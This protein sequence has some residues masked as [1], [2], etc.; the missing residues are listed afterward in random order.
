MKDDSWYADAVLWAV[1]NGITDGLTDTTFAPD[2]TCTRSQ[3]V[4]FLHRSHGSRT[5]GLTDHP[6][7]DVPSGKWYEQSV[8][9]ALENGITDGLTD[10]TF[11][12][13]KGCTRA[14]VVTFL[15]RADSLPD[16]EPEP[17]PQPFPDLG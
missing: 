4:T 2:G 14:Q 1:E 3:V 16:P 15:H 13:D 10:T 6:F 12:P 11:G 17:D 8:L 5:P 7:T 9:W